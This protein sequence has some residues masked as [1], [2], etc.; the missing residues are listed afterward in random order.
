MIYW[1]T[2]YLEC[3]GIP[4]G[5][6]WSHLGYQKE[7]FGGPKTSPGGGVPWG[8]G[9]IPEKI[10]KI[11]DLGTP[12]WVSFWVIFVYFS[13]L[14]FDLF[15]R[16]LL[17]HFFRKWDPTTEPKGSPMESQNRDFSENT[18][19]PKIDYSSMSLLLVH[20]SKSLFVGPQEHCFQHFSRPRFRDPIFP[21][22]G[23]K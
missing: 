1:Y 16:G 4:N 6:Y 11:I 10:S 9:S 19:N 23:P 7:Q 20:P 14:I 22:W 18:E 5:W 15:P 2:L 3:F 21:I 13:R 8:G 12:I 17:E